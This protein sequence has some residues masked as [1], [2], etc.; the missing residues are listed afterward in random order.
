M[1]LIIV[2]FGLVAFL[3][4]CTHSLQKDSDELQNDKK[5]L[6]CPT[7]NPMT[8]S[9]LGRTSELCRKNPNC[10]VVS[11]GCYCPPDVK[12]ICGGH[13][14]PVCKLKMHRSYNKV[15]QH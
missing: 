4:S 14:P 5:Y 7:I 9:E 13:P 11:F 3:S 2:F 8:A 10:E 1:K 15:N 6:E 12:C